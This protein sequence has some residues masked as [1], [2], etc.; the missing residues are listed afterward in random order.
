MNQNPTIIRKLFL[1]TPVDLEPVQKII[2]G[3]TFINE[4]DRLNKVKNPEPIQLFID[5]PG[6]LVYKG[7]SLINHIKRS[8][9]PV[10]GIVTGTAYSMAF[11]ILAACDKRIAYE[12]AKLMY[13]L[14]SYVQKGNLRTQDL[15][16]KRTTEV[17]E[18]MN[19]IIIKKTKVT[20]RDL[21]KITSS[22]DDWFLTPR[23][24]KKLGI[25]DKIIY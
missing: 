15:R 11:I 20:K 24:A 2:E 3:L 23:E 22:G 7:L 17:W 12:N 14:P 13:H 10:H 9:A 6:G 19:K 4:Y 5:S 18:E 8:K 16:V 1:S 21:E 25:I